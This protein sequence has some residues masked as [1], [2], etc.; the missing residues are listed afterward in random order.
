MARVLG[1]VRLSR[2][3]DETTSPERQRA[4]IERWSAE[5][6][7]QIVGWATDLD[8]SGAVAPWKRP[9]LGEWLPNSI[10][11]EASE[12]EQRISWD[13]SRAAEWDIVCS[14]KLD[15]L[16]RKVMHVWQLHEWCKSNGKTIASAEDRI[17]L[18]EPTGEA[19]FSI[20][21]TFAQM[22]LETIRFRAKDSFNEL[23][24]TGRWRGGF[25]PY[26]YRSEKAPDGKGYRLALD[27]YGTDTAGALR[28]VVERII[29]GESINSVCAWLNETGAP[30]S[31]D[32]QRVREGKEPKGAIWR[33]GNLTK[34]L[35][36]QTLLGWSEMTEETRDPHGKVRKTTRVVRGDDGLP[37]QRAEPLLDRETFDRLQAVLDERRS[38]R[39]AAATR[40]DRSM[41]LGIAQCLCGTQLYTYKGRSH[42]YYRCGR[43]GIAGVQCGVGSRGIKQTELE[44]AVAHA[45][46]TTV[47][48]L[49]MIERIYVP[50]EDH[51]AEIADALRA[52]DDLESDRAAGLY[53]TL[54][55]AERF[56]AQHEALSQRL[57]QLE[58]MP[59]TPGQ[60]DE[61]P[62]GTT[63][64]ERWDR[65][66]SQQERNTELRAAG[67]VAI[68][69]QERLGP[70]G[71]LDMMP[72][73][74]RDYYCGNYG[75][76]E[77]R[78]PAAIRDSV[79]RNAAA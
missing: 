40:G 24:R 69:H 19:L 33:V 58:A 25:V 51:S 7:H 56:R 46:L 67:V 29:S 27:D 61:R 47:G 6:G 9:A 16:S 60:W 26:G 32:A 78:T 50:G 36:S 17:D 59:S 48:D 38:P 39:K 77:I 64:R 49:E 57:E 10:G 70:I 2:D 13:R 45:F 30:T 4:S 43:K 66:T 41:L 5:Q 63:Y 35:R 65:L 18:T 44:D 8:V 72:S 79:R 14:W 20:L 37:V 52:L 12:L 55:T 71:M 54:R 76:V 68:L 21:A 31:L 22:E 3:R 15:R 11:R 34:M 28:A 62:T 74:D 42:Y 1:V 53:R 23:M 73:A 75:R